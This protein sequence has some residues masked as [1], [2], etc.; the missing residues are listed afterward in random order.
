[1]TWTTPIIDRTLQDVAIA[2][3]MQSD[4][5]EEL[6][7]AMD[8]RTLTRIEDNTQ[9][10]LSILQDLGYTDCLLIYTDWHR[11]RD[12]K[13]SDMRKICVNINFL[14]H[15]FA[16]IGLPV[17][18]VANPDYNTIND[19]ENM[20][21]VLKDLTDFLL[22]HYVVSGEIVSAE[23]IILKTRKYNESDGITTNYY[24]VSGEIV[25]AEQIIYK[26]REGN[27]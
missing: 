18:F 13:Y 11:E 21:L 8:W 7:G 14:R 27:K 24:V 5:D 22:G 4:H 16:K 6:K 20:L 19:I 9:Y 26:M 3:E 12:L 2:M 23:Q 25:S 1:M 10:V 17:E 15:I